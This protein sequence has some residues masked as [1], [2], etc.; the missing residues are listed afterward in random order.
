MYREW[1]RLLADYDGKLNRYVPT[2]Q[3][4]GC[5]LTNL[6]C[7][8]NDLA[9]LVWNSLCTRQGVTHGPTQR[10]CFGERVS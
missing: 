2:R 10:D 3:D 1:C 8:S 7:I 9:F 5:V 6:G 4:G